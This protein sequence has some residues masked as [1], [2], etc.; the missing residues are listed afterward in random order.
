MNIFWETL[1]NK[2]SQDL[3]ML[4]FDSKWNNIWSKSSW[5]T[6]YDRWDGLK[7]YN[8]W[9]YVVWW[10]YNDANIFWKDLSSTGSYDIFIA[11]LDKDWNLY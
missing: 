3:F 5:W 10:Y 7:I 1:V 8:N 6:G 9:I 4:K 11:K 2:W